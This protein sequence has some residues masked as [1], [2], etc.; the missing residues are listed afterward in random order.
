MSYKRAFISHILS[1]KFSTSMS[2][3]FQVQVKHFILD[4]KLLYLDNLSKNQI[5]V[6]LKVY[7]TLLHYTMYSIVYNTSSV[8]YGTVLY[9]NLLYVYLLYCTV[10]YYYL[11]RC[12]ACEV[13]LAS[14]PILEAHL[15][16][17]DHKVTISKQCQNKNNE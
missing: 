2:S 5:T 9:R 3:Y 13:N 8:L 17:E 14:E 7:C 10:R 6:K 4:F 16:S 15:N 11:S 1:L 12:E